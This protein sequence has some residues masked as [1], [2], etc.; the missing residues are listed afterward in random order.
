MVEYFV[1]VSGVPRRTIDISPGAGWRRAGRALIAAVVLTMVLPLLWLLGGLLVLTL[2]G[3][4]AAMFAA[5][6]ARQWWRSRRTH[7][8]AIDI[9][10]LR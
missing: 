7:D 6:F 3:G 4:A 1:H 10:D 2:L 8:P 5:A 9:V